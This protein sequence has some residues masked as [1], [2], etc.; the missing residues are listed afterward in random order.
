MKIQKTF[1]IKKRQQGATLV[2]AM[3]FLVLMTIVGV[4]ASRNSA[5]DALI[6]SN[7]QQRVEVRMS[8]AAVLRKKTT[9]YNV[10]SN[11]PKDTNSPVTL[12]D[13]SINGVTVG[14]SINRPDVYSYNCAGV[15][16][17]AN[18]LG[19]DINC[20]IFD[21]VVK[22]YKEGSGARNELVQ[23]VGK[24]HPNVSDSSY[25]D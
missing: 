7:D 15:D 9:A 8:S 19:P 25:L 13:D 16:D 2:T 1:V 18:S 6:A 11:M 14:V 21:V 5:Q 3:V 23:G 12:E 22:G 4:S 10:I 24:E 20:I 17:R